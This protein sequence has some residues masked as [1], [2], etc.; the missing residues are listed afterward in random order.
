MWWLAGESVSLVVVVLVGSFGG[1]IS[2]CVFLWW[3]LVVNVGWVCLCV[4][5]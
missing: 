4:I 1:C 2:W 3:L 5:V